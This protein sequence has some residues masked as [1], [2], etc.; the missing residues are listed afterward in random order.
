MYSEFCTTLNEIEFR[1]IY[2]FVDAV[3]CLIRS[4]LKNILIAEI[5]MSK[6]IL[7][8]YLGACL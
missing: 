3:F 6:N 5:Q 1:S 7:Q 2:L 8:E 4:M